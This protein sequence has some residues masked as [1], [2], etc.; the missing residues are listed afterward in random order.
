[1]TDFP[2]SLIEFQCRFADA[3]FLR[4]LS[5]VGALA[6]RLRLSGLRP[7]QGLAA[8]DQGLH[9]RM[10]ALSPPDLGDGGH[11][12]AR[13]E[14]AAYG[15]V[16]GRLSDGDTFQRHLGAATA[17]AARARLLQDGLAA[18]RQAASRH[19]RRPLAGLVEVDETEIACRSKD[20]QP[21]AGG[22]RSHVE[23]CWSPAPW[24]SKRP[25]PAASGWRRSMTIR[26]TACAP[27]SGLMSPPWPW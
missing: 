14:G 19:G 5:G 13:L 24:R 12:D 17:Y 22:G 23:R 9:L 18:V 16:L 20:D 27:L 6:R 10:R 21:S 26:P 25:G 7:H 1:M 3:A 4:R 8:R 11:G 15:V 2:R